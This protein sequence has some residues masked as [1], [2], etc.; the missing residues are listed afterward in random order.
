MSYIKYLLRSAG[1]LYHVLPTG[2][3]RAVFA[4]CPC[5]APSARLG[6]FRHA[7]RPTLR[8]AESANHPVDAVSA[9]G[10]DRP[11]Y[12]SL[13]DSARVGACRVG[14]EARSA[15]RTDNARVL[16]GSTV[17]QVAE[18]GIGPA[19]REA[20]A[21]GKPQ[22]QEVAYIRCWIKVDCQRPTRHKWR[23]PGARS[24]ESPDQAPLHCMTLTSSSE[25]EKRE[26]TTASP[27]AARRPGPRRH[28]TSPS[29]SPPSLTCAPLTSPLLKR[30]AGGG[31]GRHASCACC[32]RRERFRSHPCL[33]HT[34]PCA[35]L[36]VARPR[37]PESPARHVSFRRVTPRPYPRYRARSRSPRRTSTPRSSCFLKQSPSSS[38]AGSGSRPPSRHVSSR[39]RAEHLLAQDQDQ[40]SAPTRPVCTSIGAKR[41]FQDVRA[42]L[43]GSPGHARSA[44]PAV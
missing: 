9:D 23:G 41:H 21:S 30:E 16:D 22:G 28:V 4:L 32:S 1:I 25:G 35:P 5:A 40:A 8:F 26:P 15:P 33:R 7:A 3:A 29:I 24:Q 31:I 6:P 14:A 37:L 20:G 27:G 34:R 18:I 17:P 36:L 38:L 2:S 10:D 44:T 12:S 42:M 19:C 11:R 39:G 13:C 43:Q